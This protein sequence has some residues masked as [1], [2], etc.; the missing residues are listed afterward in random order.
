MDKHYLLNEFP[1]Q[2]EK[3]LDL[4]ASDPAFKTLYDEYNTVNHEVERIE[5]GLE[6]TSDAYLNELRLKR[7]ELKDQLYALLQ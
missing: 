6:P 1:E 3:I 5:N 4:K 7:V 2:K